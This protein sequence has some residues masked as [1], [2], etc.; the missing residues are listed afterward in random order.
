MNV[1]KQM[2]KVWALSCLI[3]GAPVAWMN[4]EP[5]SETP[6]VS[7]QRN[8]TGVVKDKS[9]ET[10]PGANILVK[11]TTNGVVTDM[12]G[13]YTISGQP[14]YTFNFARFEAQYRKIE[15]TFHTCTYL[16]LCLFL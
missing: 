14:K 2:P 3:A 4:A 10:I 12:D 15:F 8:L 16:I 11:E 1:G 5:V 7:Q 6:V 13:N 9:G